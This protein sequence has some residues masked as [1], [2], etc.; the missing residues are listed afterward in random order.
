MYVFMYGYVWA[1]RDIHVA[2]DTLHGKE[3]PTSN[4]WTST[5]STRSCAAFAGQNFSL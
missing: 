3:D 2:P 4:I 1:N 5:T